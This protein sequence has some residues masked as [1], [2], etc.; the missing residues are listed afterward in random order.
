MEHTELVFGLYLKLVF[1]LDLAWEG[2]LG[3]GSLMGHIR[4]AV[5]LLVSRWGF[6]IEVVGHWALLL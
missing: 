6:F 2:L 5:E 4:Y 1:A 3:E